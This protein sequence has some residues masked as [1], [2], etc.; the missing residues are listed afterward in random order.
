MDKS[1]IRVEY[2]KVRKIAK[3]FGC[4][5]SMVSESL[6]GYKNTMLSIKIRHVALT[7][8]GGKELQEVKQEY[9]ELKEAHLK[10]V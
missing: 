5:E 1:I 4:S 6:N 2:G 10:Q 7:Q 9:T 3:A 8:F